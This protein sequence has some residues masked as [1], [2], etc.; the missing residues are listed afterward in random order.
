MKQLQQAQQKMEEIKAKLDT[1]S[2]DGESPE[3]KVKVIVTGNKKVKG[4]TF[5]DESI[6]QDPEM[7][8]DYLVMATNDALEKA[9]K[10]NEAE[11][12]SVA[13]SMMPGLGG[14]FG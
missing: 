3:G 6:T 5:V 11:M 12:R 1:I 13:G 14:M 4:I 9:E 7:L 2:V 10:V 8:E